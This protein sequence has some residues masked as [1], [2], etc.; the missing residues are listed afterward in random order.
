[1]IIRQIIEKNV[2]LMAL[3]CILFLLSIPPGFALF[4]QTQDMLMPV[5]DELKSQVLKESEIETAYG[6]FMNNY[7]ICALLLFLGT[8]VVPVFFVMLV[9]GFMVGFVMKYVLVKEHTIAFFIK[10]VLLHSLFELPAIF[11]SGAIGMR[12]GLSFITS[13]NGKRVRDVSQSIK[14]A[15][16]VHVFVVIPMLAVAALIETFISAALIS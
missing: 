9:N 16:I 2:R 11:L 14:E 4:E 5:I 12:I 8:M 6:I 7:K 1:M 13:D 15:L 10:G 3:C